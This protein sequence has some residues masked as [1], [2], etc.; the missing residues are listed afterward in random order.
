MASGDH[1]SL[2][3]SN[4]WMVKRLKSQHHILKDSEICSTHLTHPLKDWWAGS[5]LRLKNNPEYRMY[6]VYS[7]WQ[8]LPNP[9]PTRP[10]SGRKITLDNWGG[11]F[12]SRGG[13]W[14]VCCSSDPPL[15]GL[16]V[17]SQSFYEDSSESLDS[18][19]PAIFGIKQL[20]RFL[21]T[22]S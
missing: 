12:G 5:V 21:I 2:I 11:W 15:N 19:N 3:I 18:D 17:Q 13:L 14:N 22:C 1:Q 6:H 4:L 7:I 20:G 9:E 10:I 16:L 8:P